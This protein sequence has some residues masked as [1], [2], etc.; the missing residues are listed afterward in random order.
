MQ[1]YFFFLWLYYLLY[2]KCYPLPQT[3]LSHPPSPCFYVGAST[4]THTLLPYYPS[5]PLCSCIESSQDQWPPLLLMPNKAILCYICS[6]S[7]MSLHAYIFGWGFSPCEL[8][9]GERVWLVDTVVFPMGLQ[10]PSAPSAL[11][12]NSSIVGPV[13]SPVVSWKHLHLYWSGSGGVSQETTRSGSCQ[14]ALLGISN[15]V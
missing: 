10:T 12:L 14:H 7:H 4:P 11:P 5:I 8:G 1:L 15:S 3:P 6:C 9:W 2:F 13:L